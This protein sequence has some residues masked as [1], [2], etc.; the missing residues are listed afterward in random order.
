MSL[1]NLEKEY[2]L[3]ESELDELMQSDDEETQKLANAKLQEVINKSLEIENKNVNIFKYR[4]Y[5]LG[6]EEQIRALSE[7]HKKEA[8]RLD[9][10]ADTFANKI[11]QLDRST[12]NA[13]EINGKK[14]I[15]TE[16][17]KMTIRKSKGRIDILDKK[18]IPDS[19]K[20]ERVSTT[21]VENKTAIR[22]AIESGK[23]VPGAKLVFEDTL[24]VK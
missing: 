23:N 18:L 9:D 6:K 13:L 7:M 4:F 12:I 11:K 5:L 3:L 16:L 20:K 21:L 1:Y 22:E 15:E 2:A 19:Y 14:S 8:K 24:I 17:G 10:Y